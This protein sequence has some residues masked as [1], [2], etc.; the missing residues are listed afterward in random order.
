M[1]EFDER[2]LRV[3]APLAEPGRRNI[4][5]VR[6]RRAVVAVDAHSGKIAWRCAIRR[7]PRT[8]EGSLRA[9]LCPVG[10]FRHC[11][12]AAP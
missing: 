9:Q 7:G 11:V 8:K 3:P 10:P 1:S 5:T 12:L 6:T 2:T 4:F